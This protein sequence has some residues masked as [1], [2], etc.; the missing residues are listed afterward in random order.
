MIY[1]L[2]RPIVWV[3]KMVKMV[4]GAPFRAL[5]ARRDRHARKDARFAATAIREQQKAAKKAAS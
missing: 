2:T 5:R 3:I 4:L 1:L